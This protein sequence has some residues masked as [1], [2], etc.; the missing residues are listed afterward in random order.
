VFEQRAAAAGWREALAFE[1]AE[2]G[3]NWALMA[4]NLDRAVGLD[5]RPSGAASG[6]LGSLRERMLARDTATGHWQPIPVQPGC[7]LDAGNGWSCACP[8]NGAGSPAAP[9]GVQPTSRFTLTL[10]TGARPGSL[11]LESRGCIGAASSC[12]DT[13]RGDAQAVVHVDLAALRTS[14][15]A[16]PATLAARGNVSLAGPVALSNAD[17]AAGGLAVDAGGAIA[18][19]G[20]VR[21]DGP[22]GG[23]GPPAAVASDPRW[24]DASGVPLS[25]DAYFAVLFGLSRARYRELPSLTRLTCAGSCN[26]AIVDAALAAGARALWLDGPLDIGAVNWGTPQRPILLFVDGP[27]TVQGPA[28]LHALVYSRALVWTNSDL[29]AAAVRGALISEGDALLS[30]V[31]AAAYD[32]DVLSRAVQGG[33][34]LVQLPG[35]W[36]DFTD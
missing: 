16:A 6:S 10:R 32:A 2:A 1:A 11:V 20:Q 31:I 30:G 28:R 3:R 9:G 29:A 14:A 25:A 33:S 35:G 7:T 23:A 27:L 24:R 8:L 21:L 36:R 26:A 12:D 18:A 13:H 17:A 34:F 4:L 19:D 22:P 15:D 5:C